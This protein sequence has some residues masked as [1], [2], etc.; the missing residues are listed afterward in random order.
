MYQKKS[1]FRN[2]LVFSLFLFIACTSQEL[3]QQ[4]ST[5]TNIKVN[6][7]PTT[8]VAQS[9]DYLGTTLSGTT[10]PYLDFNI[11]DY[12]KALQENKII[13]LNF[14]A[15][16][17]PTCRREQPGIFSAFYK[18]DNPNIIGFRINYKDSYTDEDEIDL[19]RKYGITY[20]HT[21]VILKDGEV[22]KKELSQWGE[23][24][25]INELSTLE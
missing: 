9:P 4:T 3:S 14:Y 18:L 10:T 8:T 16:W 12:E 13:F 2:L 1:I 17:C 24:K 15:D 5:E 20:Q 21:K 11:Q 6:E 19:A 22:I 7:P 23:E 25:T